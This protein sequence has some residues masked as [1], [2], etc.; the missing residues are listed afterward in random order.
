MQTPFKRLIEPLFLK[1]N[2][3]DP[4]WS[5]TSTQARCW[6]GGAVAAD[7]LAQYLVGMPNPMTILASLLT[8]IIFWAIPPRLSGAV[9]GL[10]TSQALVSMLVVTAASMAGNM[11]V[12]D[13][14]A[15]LWSA[16][17]M[18]AL[19][20]LILGYIRTPKALM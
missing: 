9:G 20:R 19:V 11:A 5:V 7:L 2:F 17:C 14:A 16:W 13:V 1:V 8:L 12:V 6:L 3:T 4:Y 10:Y 18:F 15:M